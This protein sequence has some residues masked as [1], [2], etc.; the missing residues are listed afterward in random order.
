MTPEFSQRLL[1]WFDHHGRKTLPWQQAVSPYRVWV[2]EIMLQQ[3]QVTTVIPYF[4]RFMERFP[5]VESLAE[6]NEDEVL[7]LWTGLGYYA[8][9]R[10]LHKAARIIAGEWQGSFPTHLDDLEALPGI[11]RSTAGA[12]VSIAGGGRAPIL[13]GNVKRV[14]SRCFGIEGWPGQSAVATELWEKAEALTPHERVAAYTQAIMDLGATVCVRSS[15]KCAACPFEDVCI[16]RRDG[17]IAEL[18]GKK[19]KKELPVRQTAM[20][21]VHNEQGEVLLLRRPGEGL[22]GGLWNFP[23]CAPTEIDA[24]IDAIG[25]LPIIR[26]VHQIQRLGEFRNTFTHFHL[27]ITPVHIIVTSADAINEPGQCWYSPN[28]PPELGLTRP[29]VRLLK[30]LPQVKDV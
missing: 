27:D 11:G 10:N 6:A 24:G 20:L 13:D 8:R 18:P 16:A 15:P 9:A 4:E 28:S 2:S 7:H 19:P 3:T 17:R 5:T 23:E 22:W 25:Q 1:D 26:E 29:V 14:L 30:S 12:I 21:I